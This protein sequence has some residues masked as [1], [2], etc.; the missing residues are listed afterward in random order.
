MAEPVSTG[1]TAATLAKYGIPALMSLGGN[2]LGSRS[3]DRASKRAARQAAASQLTGAL[4]NPQSYGGRPSDMDRSVMADTLT[5]PV[6]QQ[7]MAQLLAGGN[8]QQGLLQKLMGLFGGA[9]TINQAA[10]G[11]GAPGVTGGLP[12]RSGGAGLNQ[13]GGYNINPNI[14]KGLGR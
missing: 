12:L 7:L 13:G 8:G 3:Q 2:V 6:T 1:L 10:R 14:L 9:D 5:D 4:G 11:M